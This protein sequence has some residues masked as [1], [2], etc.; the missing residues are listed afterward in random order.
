[1]MDTTAETT[2]D[3]DAYFR[4]IGYEGPPAP[5]LDT[6]R[7]IHAL[8]PASIAFE[9]LNPLLGWEVKLDAASLQEKLVRQGRGGWCF[10]QNLL[11]RDVLLALGFR[12]TG[13]AGRVMW[14]QPPGEVRPRS[15]MLLRVDLDEGTYV[16]DV[17]FGGVTLTAPLRL[18]AEEEQPTP[19]EPFRLARVDDEYVMQVKIRG[20]WQSLYRFDLQPQHRADYEVTSWYLCHHPRSHFRA[21][22]IAARSAPGL[23]HALRDGELVTHHANGVTERRV[24]ADAADLREALETTFRLTLPDA[25][26]LDTALERLTARP[27]LA[28]A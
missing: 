18:D 23:R 13:L 7:A 19:H 9:N 21:G 15:H 12:V 26:E 5:T 28:G 22:L 27:A 2:I 1:M 25:P 24:I 6:L 3:L 17:G 11:L 4:R 14:N 20:E 10:E 8:H 16:A